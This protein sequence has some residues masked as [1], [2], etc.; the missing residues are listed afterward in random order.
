VPNAIYVEGWVTRIPDF[1][2]VLQSS[3]ASISSFR[4]YGDRFDRFNEGLLVHEILLH[5]PSLQRVRILA[6]IS[7]TTLV[8]V[9]S[10]IHV[11]FDGFVPGNSFIRDLLCNPEA[12]PQLQTIRLDEYPVWELLFAMLRERNKRGFPIIK[13]IFLRGYPAAPILSKLVMLLRGRSDVYTTRSID[14]VIYRRFARGKQRLW[15]VGFSLNCCD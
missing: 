11:H 14:E 9:K 7:C 6:Y 2:S 8:H 13:Q 1:S 15:V 4:T 10:L 5:W 3:M 12:C